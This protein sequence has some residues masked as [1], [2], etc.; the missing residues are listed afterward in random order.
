MLVSRFLFEYTL[1]PYVVCLKCVTFHTHVYAGMHMYAYPHCSKGEMVYFSVSIKDKYSKY[2]F[3]R[4]RLS[5]PLKAL[6]FASGKQMKSGPC[7]TLEI[8]TL[9]KTPE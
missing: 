1:K 4:K 8:L 9:L 6:R 7:E 3:Y 5:S 2:F